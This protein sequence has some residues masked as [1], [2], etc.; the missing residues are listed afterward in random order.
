MF[1]CEA[2]DSGF[3]R[4]GD[5]YGQFP[6]VIDFFVACWVVVAVVEERERERERERASRKSEGVDGVRANWG[7]S[8]LRLQP[9]NTQPQ[10]VKKKTRS[11]TSGT[12][13][14]YHNK[15]L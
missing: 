3:H 9:E 7:V 10:K 6:H 14:I 1:T 5:L 2:V 11:C 4:R 13:I 15:Q 8:E 12:I